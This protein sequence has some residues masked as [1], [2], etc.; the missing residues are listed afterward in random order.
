MR[1]YEQKNTSGHNVAAPCQ[2]TLEV[3]WFSTAIAS[4]AWNDW[5]DSSEDIY[6]E[7]NGDP[8]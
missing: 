6:T 5:L 1:I 2:V 4:G 3:D 7:N 8:L